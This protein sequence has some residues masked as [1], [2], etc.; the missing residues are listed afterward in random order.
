MAWIK[1]V[2]SFFT[3]LPLKTTSESPRSLRAG[4]LHAGASAVASQ[5]VVAF[6]TANLSFF[7]S[8]LRPLK[9]PT[10]IIHGYAP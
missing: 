10:A 7:G 4:T 8:G 5:R 3:L 6:R 9:P 1:M 2:P